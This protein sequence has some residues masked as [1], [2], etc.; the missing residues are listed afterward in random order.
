MGVTAL[1]FRLYSLLHMFKN[2]PN[3]IKVLNKADAL[4]KLDA[5][6]QHHE[7]TKKRILFYLLYMAASIPLHVYSLTFAYRA[8][9]VAFFLFF[10]N[11]F[12]NLSVVSTEF[13]FISLCYIIQTRFEIIN[14][15]LK[16]Q[17]GNMFYKLHSSTGNKLI[18]FNLSFFNKRFSVTTA[19]ICKEIDTIM[20]KVY[21]KGVQKSMESKMADDVLVLRNVHRILTN[22]TVNVNQHYNVRIL[23]SLC[24]CIINMLINTYFAIF[25]GY[26]TSNAD[27]DGNNVRETV[28]AIVWSVY[29]LQRFIFICTASEMICKEVNSCKYSA[30][31][32]RI[33]C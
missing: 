4:L 28:T 15:N 1:V 23:L 18:F 26:G 10:F 20:L 12:N 11:S 14:K 5:L 33:K 31:L 27:T 2:L 25:G 9:P 17:F 6:H 3:V 13:Q 7:K 22:L 16:S 32:K 8:D 21:E 29:Y 24:C 30:Q 19:N